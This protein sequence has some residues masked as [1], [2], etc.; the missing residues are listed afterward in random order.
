MSIFFF[1]TAYNGTQQNPLH[2]PSSEIKQKPFHSPSSHLKKK[3][4]REEISNQRPVGSSACVRRIEEPG[5]ESSPTDPS[6]ASRP[7]QKMG[8]VRENGY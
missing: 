7:R 5:R 4:T 8:L 6:Y 2:S 1:T 3:A